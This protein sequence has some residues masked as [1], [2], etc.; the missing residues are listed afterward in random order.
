MN[1]KIYHG[2]ISIIEKPTYGLGKKYN[3]Y[4]LGFYCTEDINL[5]KEWAAKNDKNGFVNEYAIDTN[6]LTI[7]NLNDNK[8]C[9]LHWIAILIQ[10]REF[11]SVSPLAEEAKEYIL[12]NF[13][14]NYKNADII[15]G[16]RA[17]D[18]YFSFAQDFL[19]GTISYR[20]LSNS[21]KLGNLGEQF[22][23]KSKEAFNRLKF[24]KSVEV[25][26]TEWYSKAKVRDTSARK[27]YFNFEKNK[28]LPGDIF[29]AQIID[30]RMNE[31]DP[32]LR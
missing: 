21:M 16:Y 3:D 20:Q 15:I 11:D 17:D 26:A 31:N 13:L 32:R 2:S 19:N 18:S 24:V 25:K 22:V 4:G 7:L 28:R 23:I 14:I 9:I 27:E 30:E 8:Y 1:K 29:I 10:N 5:A 12:N 6:G